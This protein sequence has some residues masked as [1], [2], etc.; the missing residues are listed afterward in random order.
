MAI[1]LNSILYNPII[2]KQDILDNVTQESI[3]SFYMQE[4][5][6]DLGV[7]NSPLREDN[8]PSFGLF[9]HS[10]EKDVLMFR[11]FATGDTGDCVVLVSKMFNLSFKDSLYKIAFDM[12]LTTY[13]PEA[14]FLKK[15]YPKLN[16][17]EVVKLGVKTREWEQ[18][19][20]MFWQKHGISKK[21]LI[22][23]NVYPI[24]HIF[25]NDTAVL[26]HYLAYVYV[27]FK[28]NTPSFKIYQPLE[29]KKRKWINN[30]NYSVH[31][32]YTQLPKTGD[33]LII[34]KSLKDVMSIHDCVDLPAIGLQS[35][36]ILMKQSVMDEYQSRFKKVYCLFD[37]DAA[38][39][40]LAAEFYT[41]FNIPHFFMP[42]LPNVTDFSDL[43]REV[44]KKEAEEIFFEQSQI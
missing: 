32:G 35:E 21:T 8:I 44:G 36:S 23:F 5:V 14:Q 41:K 15:D 40:K 31:Q 22:K 42:K 1:N 11:D 38:G 43:V 28:D 7:Y 17:K 20:K 25:Y 12:G 19:D 10:R 33:V 24:S 30:A 29:D 39:E 27:E 26:A 16:R 4:D 34:T 13:N 9:Y 37:N 2:T 3:Y 6:T 18:K